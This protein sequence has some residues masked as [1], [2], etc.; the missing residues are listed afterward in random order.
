VGLISTRRVKDVVLTHYFVQISSSGVL[1]DVTLQV[2]SVTVWALVVE[3]RVCEP[4]IAT[5]H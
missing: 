2:F 4:Q 1:K 3:V 5:V